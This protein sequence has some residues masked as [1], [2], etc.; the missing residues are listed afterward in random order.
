MNFLDRVLRKLGMLLRRGRFHDEL[1]EEM[2]F[3]RDE[4]VREF[5]ADGMSREE[6][7]YAAV[8]QFG[9]A[10]QLKD[11]SQEA[12]GFRWES[13]MHD[14][15]F[16]L[17]QFRKNPGFTVTAVLMLALGLGASVAI[18]A[19]V[20][21][22]LIKP[23]PYADP[24]RLV[25]VTESEV[26]IQRVNLSY[27]DYQDWKRMNTVF[28]SLNAFTG[29]NLLLTTPTGTE[30][31]QG[32][33]VG[34]GFF[35]TLGVAPILGRDFYSSEEI[36]GGPHVVMLSYGTWQRRFGG[37][38]SVIGQSVKLSGIAHTIIGVLPQS[39]A[40]APGQGAEF[41]AAL[42]PDN[43]CEKLR[44]CHNLYA[45]GRLRDGVPVEMA[46]ANMQS[47]AQQLEK[48][49]PDT[50]QGRGASVMPL[51]ERIVGDVR[52]ILFLLLGGVSLLLLIACVNV[53]SLLMVRSESR[54]RE[55]AVRGALG[56]SR[57]RIACQ[58]ATEG[59]VL[60]AGGALVGLLFADG[61]MRILSHLISKQMMTN[62]PYLQGLGM[63]AHV[64]IFAG[65]LALL[66]AMLFSAMPILHLRSSDIRDGL[67]EGGRASA[68]TLWRR[69]GGRLVVIELATT[70]VLLTAAGL[71]GQSL[72]RLLHVEVGFPV[73]HLA[74]LQVRLSDTEFPDDPEQIAFTR[75]ILERIESL[76]GVR[77][78]AVTSVMPVSCNCNSD[79][80]RIAGRPYNG[81]H[82]TV[83]DR[84]VSSEFFNTLHAKLLAGRYFSDAEDES[85]PGVVIVNHAF[86]RKY[87]PGEDPIGKRMGDQTLSSSS[88]RQIVGVVEDFKDGALDELQRATVYYP[89]N[90]KAGSNL[91]LLVRT[92]QD[93]RTILPIVA[94][95]IHQLNPG[96][97]VE[98][99]STMSEQ[100]NDSQTAYFHRSSA[101]LVGG[102]AAL[103][104]VLSVVGL[105]GVI[106]YSVSQRTRE[107]GVRMALGAQRGTVYAMILREAGWLTVIGIAAGVVGSIG[108]GLL[109][110]SLLFGVKSWDVSTLFAV[111][112]VLAGAAAI[113]S[114]LPARRAASVNPVE[115]LRAE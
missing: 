58:L 106:A 84:N 63:N 8:R 1:D 52:P 56:A 76:P 102:F 81:D 13:V 49:Y 54:K 108:A 70:M 18:F 30:P 95:A 103:A 27:P 12:V 22:A 92:A 105:Y 41:W 82:I 14:L 40:F 83:N 113:A 94:A 46:L 69:M 36:L 62:M 5:E 9:N 64:L 85:K 10:A 87:F 53:S 93:E 73:D 112:V 20:D 101:Y 23:L 97:G 37:R 34:A 115:A 3:H 80:I 25:H 28:S 31:L 86:A 104:L 59:M 55:I 100:I 114:Y 77:S 15:R 89:Y 109:M 48:Q 24:Q 45:V 47:I 35:R 7:R 66:A 21:A 38:K 2:A 111:A 26:A 43:S 75:R 67:T 65:A 61:A 33:R 78:T 72:Y 107:I 44:D 29:W 99:G 19:F 6:A 50:N 88:I 57:A 71:L 96:V 51:S 91:V 16:A 68:G 74:T 79:W 39:F 4:A 32:E 17:R 98:E 110:R 90:Q 60:V 42:Q 11:K